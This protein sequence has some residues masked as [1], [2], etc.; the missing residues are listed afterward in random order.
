M[1]DLDYSQ[2]FTN[3]LRSC[4]NGFLGLFLCFRLPLG[5]MFCPFHDNRNTPAAKRYG[6]FIK[7]FSC[8]R[9]YGVYDLLKEFNP[10]RLAQV[11]MN[12]SLDEI[13]VH[14]RKCKYKKFKIHEVDRN[15]SMLAILLDLKHSFEEETTE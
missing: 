2:Y 14:T 9:T 10:S 4:F 15:R 6:N 13:D 1:R 11:R 12:V 8:G 3:H 5:K 7:C